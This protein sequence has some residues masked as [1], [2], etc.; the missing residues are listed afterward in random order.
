MREAWVP[1]I[2]MFVDI[3]VNIFVIYMMLVAAVLPTVGYK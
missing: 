2:L 3:A 1:F